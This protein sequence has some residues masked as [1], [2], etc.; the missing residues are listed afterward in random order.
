MATPIRLERIFGALKG[1]L[2]V[3]ELVYLVL[4]VV[5]D[6]LKNVRLNFRLY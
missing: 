1:S 2:T 4:G 5:V 3:V 6:A